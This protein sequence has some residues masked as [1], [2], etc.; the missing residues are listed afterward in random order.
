V[1]LVRRNRPL[2]LTG[3]AVII[4]F[5]TLAIGSPIVAFRINRDRLE[6]E[7][8]RQHETQ[9][10][11]QAQA[12]ELVSRQKAYASDTSAASHA[13]DEGNFGLARKLL[14]GHGPQPGQQT[15]A[16]LSGV[17]CGPNPGRAT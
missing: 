12:Q 2:A 8:A 7:A 14:T 15:C 1:A 10:R 4:L 17:I 13:L 5:V 3:A 11:L 6:A 9:L 16:A